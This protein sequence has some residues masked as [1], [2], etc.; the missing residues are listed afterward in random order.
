[1]IVNELRRPHFFKQRACLASV[2]TGSGLPFSSSSSF[3]LLPHH[4]ENRGERRKKTTN[5]NHG[6]QHQPKQTQCTTKAAGVDESRSLGCQ[7]SHDCGGDSH[8][9]A[10]FPAGRRASSVVVGLIAGRCLQCAEPPPPPNVCHDVVAKQAS[11]AIIQHQDSIQQCLSS[12]QGS[13]RASPR[14]SVSHHTAQR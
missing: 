11:S 8:R 5:N 9:G 13:G 6:D 4:R 2:L 14:G 12:R 3:S 10:K 1:M 7:D